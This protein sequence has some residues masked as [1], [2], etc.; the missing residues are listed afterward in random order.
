MNIEQDYL[1]FHAKAFWEKFNTKSL[2]IFFVEKTQMLN[3]GYRQSD[4]SLLVESEQDLYNLSLQHG[5]SIFS[6]LK[7]IRNHQY[8]DEVLK[9]SEENQNYF[10]E[11]SYSL[12]GL[13]SLSDI[14]NNVSLMKEEQL[15]KLLDN[16]QNKVELQIN[17]LPEFLDKIN[18][19]G[20]V[21]E[22]VI[23]FII[24]KAKAIHGEEN[25][26]LFK[27][28]II[29]Y[30]PG[31]LN[32]F[33]KIKFMRQYL[34]Y[35]NK[36]SSICVEQN[37]YKTIYLKIDLNILKNKYLIP[38]AKDTTYINGL[39]LLASCLNSCSDSPIAHC[40]GVYNEITSQQKYYKLYLQVD[41]NYEFTTKQLE[42]VIKEYFQLSVDKNSTN[43]MSYFPLDEKE[44]KSWLQKRIFYEELQNSVK[45]N[46]VE[47]V[48][49]KNKL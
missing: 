31:E 9:E 25:I 20:K 24:R 3:Y 43:K 45:N 23:D 39:T 27:S 34:Q 1:K 29:K 16:K 47:D 12:I 37:I 11:N 41:K 15:L 2:M 46:I 21:K 4:D 42:C 5:V 13:I 18:L 8:L 22:S 19:A 10:F 33:N 44:A 28:T 32:K 14:I 26:S 49:R 40:I 17:I 30:F 36:E 6:L 38:Q 48:K 7:S 35:S